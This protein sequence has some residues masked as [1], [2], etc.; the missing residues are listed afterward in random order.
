MSI[1]QQTPHSCKVQCKHK[2]GLYPLKIGDRIT[3]IHGPHVKNNYTDEVS[4]PPLPPLT[5][6]TQCL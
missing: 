4:T 3:C 5:V 6:W 1:H 2:G